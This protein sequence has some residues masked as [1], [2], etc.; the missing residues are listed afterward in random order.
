MAQAVTPQP[1]TSEARVLFKVIPYEICGG[2][3]TLGEVHV[4]VFRSSP[5]TITSQCSTL[6]FIY[7]SLL[8]EG[9][10]SKTGNFPES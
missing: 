8:P 2:K 9:H 5:V 7:T 4:R 3:M 10:M 1:L 6:T